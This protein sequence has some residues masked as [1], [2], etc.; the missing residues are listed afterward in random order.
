MHLRR[1]D[2]SRKAR[3]S[4]QRRSSALFRPA[5][6]QTEFS[7]S[8]RQRTMLV[9][10]L[11]D[12]SMLAVLVV[13]PSN[14][15]DYSTINLAMA[16][17]NNGD[18]IQVVA[19]TFSENVNVNKSVTIEGAQH[20][21]DARGRSGAETIVTGVGN[22]G[23]TPFDITASD[24]TIDGFKIEGA[25]NA[26]Q[27]GFG[28]VVGAGTSGAH[29]L[30][31]IF[32]NN[33]AGLS[34]AN[35]NPADPAIVQHN[36][37]ASNNQLGAFSG[38]GIY[39]DQFSA[40]GSLTNVQIDG[41]NFTG[42]SDSGIDFSSTDATK[43]ATLVTISNNDFNGNG[44]GVVA[45]N[46][47][48]SSITTNTFRNSTA[49]ATADIRLFEGVNGLAITNNLLE[50]G[51][52]KAFRVSNAGTGSPDATNIAFNGNSISGYTGPASLFQ[53]DNYSGTLDA[54]FNWWGTNNATSFP[55]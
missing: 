30:N 52:G 16:A 11:E 22:S 27:F 49:S 40:G 28:A 46:L 44:R 20:G 10:P 33:I 37:F 48:S 18:T 2:R 9:E 51:A 41:N 13:D 39:S 32:D 21:V 42:N 24:V 19:G 8:D 12:R 29:I 7:A 53:V 14:V 43:P 45:F 34:L 1:S 35:A 36:V 26:A 4:R 54:R 23:K 17:A 25:T 5:F 6:L 38:T 55:V 47:T 15:A 31:D 50:N 3:E